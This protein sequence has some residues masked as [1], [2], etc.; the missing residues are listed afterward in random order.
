MVTRLCAQGQLVGSIRIPDAVAPVTIT[1]DLRAARIDCHVDIDA[2][3]EGK[4]TTRVKW[5]VR[6]LDTAPD[7]VRIEAY[8]AHGRG[9]SAAELLGPVR[10]N[11]A[12]LIGNGAKE[13]RSF[14]IARSAPM[15]AKRGRGRGSFI[16][17]VLTAVDVFYGDV[18]QHLKAWSAAPPKLRQ[19]DAEQLAVEQPAPTSLVST[20]FS[21]QDEPKS[22]IS[23]RTQ[24]E[25]APARTTP[26]NGH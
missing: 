6:Q 16:D 23:P 4:P 14:R 3:R 7:G 19:P 10:D 13:L 12:L 8:V 15:G 2:P 21:S 20:S 11:P 26:S 1:A 5:L 9:S 22:T 18:L 24:T 25:G 17:S